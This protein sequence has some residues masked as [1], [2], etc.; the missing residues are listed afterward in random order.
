MTSRLDERPQL[1]ARAV[2]FLYL[3][4]ILLG[5]F[6]EGYLRNALVVPGDAAATVARGVTATFIAPSGPGPVSSRKKI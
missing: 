6:S 2:G 5:G 1:H 3:L 4:V